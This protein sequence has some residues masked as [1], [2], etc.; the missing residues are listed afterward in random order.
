MIRW[1]RVY[2][3]LILIID[4]WDPRNVRRCGT[5]IETTG[6]QIPWESDEITKISLCVGP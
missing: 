6:Y 4:K 3:G 1:C 2:T 5:A